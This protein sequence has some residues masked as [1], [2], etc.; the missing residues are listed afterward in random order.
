MWVPT[1]C[2]GLCLVCLIS[3][4][5]AGSGWCGLLTLVVGSHI[6]VSLC[7]CVVALFDVD[8]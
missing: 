5:L 4:G 6:L 3:A 7:D 1:L 8:V 2:F